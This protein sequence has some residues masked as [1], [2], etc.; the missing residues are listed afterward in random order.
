MRSLLRRAG[1]LFRQLL[2]CDRAPGMPLCGG[3]QCPAK[4]RHQT[5]VQVITSRFRMQPVAKRAP[6]LLASAHAA[7]PLKFLL[8]DGL[9]GVDALCLCSPALI[10]RALRRA[11]GNS[12]FL[13]SCDQGPVTTPP[14]TDTWTCGINV[15]SAPA[16]LRSQC[17]CQAPV[18]EPHVASSATPDAVSSAGSLV[19]HRP[20]QDVACLSGLTWVRSGVCGMPGCINLS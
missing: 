19:C 8:I 5:C 2:H 11:Q 16:P 6:C 17:R 9:L 1:D 7:D 4:H 18:S 10:G 3:V 14:L 13:S 15:T 12:F 20:D